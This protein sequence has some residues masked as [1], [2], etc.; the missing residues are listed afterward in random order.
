MA[1]SKQDSDEAS[2]NLIK[3][4]AKRTKKGGKKYEGKDCAAAIFELI[5][6]M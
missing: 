6:S 4:S 3:S 1:T 2:A 5:D